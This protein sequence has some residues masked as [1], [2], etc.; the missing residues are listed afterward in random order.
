MTKRRKA[1]LCDRVI[2]KFTG[3]KSFFW[4]DLHG[5]KKS[6]NDLVQNPIAVIQ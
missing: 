1:E 4:D 6:F 5:H 2:L 3:D